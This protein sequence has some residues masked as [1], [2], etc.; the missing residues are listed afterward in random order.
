MVSDDANTAQTDEERR[1]ISS[2]LLGAGLI[3]IVH[4]NTDQEKKQ[5][6]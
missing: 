6:T 3:Q 5:H 1:K 2:V 4:S